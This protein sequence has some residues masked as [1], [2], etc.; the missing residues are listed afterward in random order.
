MAA[1]E[2]TKLAFIKVEKLKPGTNGHN[3]TVKSPQL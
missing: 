1:I 3:L 2:K